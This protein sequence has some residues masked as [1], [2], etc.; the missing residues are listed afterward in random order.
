MSLEGLAPVPVEVELPRRWGWAVPDVDRVACAVVALTLVAVGLRFAGLSSQSFWGDE[1]LT[2]S[3][4]RRPLGPMFGLVLNQETTPPLYFVLA[5]AWAHVFGS[6]EA[7]IRSLSA[8]AGTAMVPLAYL[9]GARLFT[10]RVGV[11]A[12]AL[13]A[14]NPFLIWYSQEARAYAVYMTLAGLSFLCFVAVLRS[15]SLR[16]LAGWAVASALALTSHFFALFLVG[17]EAL[18]LLL[19]WPGRRSAIAVGGVAA[20]GLVLLPVGIVDTTHGTGWIAESPLAER[21]GRTAGEFALGP[22]ARTSWLGGALVVFAGVAAVGLA[23]VG[24]AMRGRERR[25][26]LLALAVGGSAVAIPLG[27]AALGADLL[28]PRNVA[29]AWLPLTIVAAA[30]LGSRRA[31]R[32]GSVAAAVVCGGSLALTVAMMTRPGLQRPDWRAVAAEMGPIT[33]AR[34]VIAD[35]SGAEPLRLYLPDVALGAASSPTVIRE[36]ALVRHISHV[37]P[38]AGCRRL[39]CLPASPPASAADAVRLPVRHARIGDYALA[40]WSLRRP[41]RVT[42]GRLRLATLRGLDPYG[43]HRILVVVQDPGT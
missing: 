35:A 22:A 14:V 43:K 36:I 28:N 19:A 29:A 4:I 13:A 32:A 12:A 33:S 5:W 11:I 26:A 37:G 20:V 8:L 17:P 7:A 25:S 38:Y 6:G 39:R 23:A 3:E 30:G 16:W 15:R 27:M 31:G 40:R 10:R 41:V 18:W 24:L 2:V 21:V 34:A 42:P 1:A 9:A